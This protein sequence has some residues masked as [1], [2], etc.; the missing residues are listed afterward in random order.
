MVAASCNDC[1]EYVKSY[2]VTDESSKGPKCLQDDQEGVATLGSVTQESDC[3]YFRRI[4]INQDSDRY[5]REYFK[6]SNMDEA[7][8]DTWSDLQYTLDPL[9]E[10]KEQ[11]PERF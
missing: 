6:E 8:V 3:P 10:A 5:P 11:H 9:R 1:K 7:T 4:T 2:S